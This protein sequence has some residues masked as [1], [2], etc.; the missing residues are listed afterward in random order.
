MVSSP[1]L[2]NNNI[3]YVSILINFVFLSL[4]FLTDLFFFDSTAFCKG[5]ILNQQSNNNDSALTSISIEEEE[6]NSQNENSSEDESENEIVD[7]ISQLTD[8]P[9]VIFNSQSFYLL[10]TFNIKIINMDI[11]EN[12]LSIDLIDDFNSIKNE[13]MTISIMLNENSNNFE[14]KQQMILYLE[15]YRNDLMNIKKLSSELFFKLDKFS[16]YNQ[17]FLRRLN[18]ENIN[19]NLHLNKCIENLNLDLRKLNL[20]NQ[21]DFKLIE[22]ESFIISDINIKKYF[23][24]DVNIKLNRDLFNIYKYTINLDNNQ[25]IFLEKVPDKILLSEMYSNKRKFNYIDFNFEENNNNLKK[26]KLYHEE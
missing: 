23:F 5:T 24:R 14:N 8:F 26:L 18:L 22:E 20:N 15:N 21:Y 1:F 12:Q 4:F 19:F 25:K 17:P 2:L 11:L 16:N 9:G 13:I 6:E 3:Q 7:I 10:S